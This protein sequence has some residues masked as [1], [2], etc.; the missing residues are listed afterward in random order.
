MG[1]TDKEHGIKSKSKTSKKKKSTSGSKINKWINAQLEAKGLSVSAAK[2]DAGKYKTISAAK[3]AGSLYYTNPQGTVK[4][5]AFASD[6]DKM[7]KKSKNTAKQA[8]ED[9]DKYDM[10]RSAEKA[11]AKI[12]EDRASS[13]REKKFGDVKKYSRKKDKEMLD[14]KK[15]A[16][17]GGS[18][19]V[20]VTVIS[21]ADKKSKKKKDS[22]PGIPQSVKDFFKKK[23]PTSKE[24]IKDFRKDL[25]K[26]D[27]SNKANFKKILNSSIYKTLPSKTQ[28]MIRNL[29]DGKIPMSEMAKKREIKK[30]M[31]SGMNVG[32]LTSSAMQNGLSRKI[33][34]STGLTMNKGGMTDYRKSG[35]FY[36]GGMARSGK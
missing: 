23:E 33:N 16:G 2:K 6:L 28:R 31:D 9:Y 4:I 11:E 14:A 25:K 5:A 17:T 36:G 26:V 29:A 18:G 35:M 1:T 30:L 24:L 3:K 12:R 7:P 8:L 20:S 27:D 32:G 15:K 21:A 19:S 34:P 13:K 10:R 22:F